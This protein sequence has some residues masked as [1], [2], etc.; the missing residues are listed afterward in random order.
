M[1]QSH[2]APRGSEQPLYKAIDHFS[3]SEFEPIRTSDSESQVR[4]GN[5]ATLGLLYPSLRPRHR[6][7]RAPLSASTLTERA[8]LSLFD[9]HQS[10]A[11]DMTASNRYAV[12]EL[13]AK[14]RAGKANDE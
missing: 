9:S 2:C 5:L 10:S 8:W 13:V 12:K 11:F 14:M 7:V 3:A 1:Y 4:M 6:L